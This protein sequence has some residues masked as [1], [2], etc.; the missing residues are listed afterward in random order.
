VADIDDDQEGRPTFVGGQG[1]GVAFGLAAGA[2][3]G[4]VKAFGGGAE[5]DFLGFEDEV[6]AL[7]AVD[8][9][10]AACCRR[11]DGR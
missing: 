11:H 2:L 8:A 4:V 7:V 10:G 3:Q 9:A 1:A 6:P 5:R